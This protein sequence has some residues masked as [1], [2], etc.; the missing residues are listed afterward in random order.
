MYG[1]SVPDPMIEISPP[2]SGVLA[3]LAGF[4]DPTTRVQSASDLARALGA[5]ELLLFTTDPETATILPAPGFPQIPR[6]AKPWRQLLDDCAR[7]GPGT[8]T[9][10]NADGELRAASALAGPEGTIAL[11]LGGEP[12]E[13]TLALL[14]PALA[15]LGAL[16]RSERREIAAEARARNARTDAEAANRVKSDFLAN[17][18]HELRTPINAVL[19]YTELLNM[20]V[21]GP[22]TGDQR[23]QLERIRV[24][25]A[26]LLTLVNDVLD[27]AKVEAGQMD[28][29]VRMEPAR[30]V[31]AE[32]VEL[33]EDSARK[34]G[35][36]LDNQGA[37]SPVR[38]VGDHDRV[39]QILLNLLSNAVKFTAE[40][41]LV[42]VRCGSSP[43]AAEPARV[44]G[45]GP[46][47]YVEVED[48]GIGLSETDLARV[49]H[50][51]VQAEMGRTRSHGGTGL[52]L[53]IS[54]QLARLMGG[55]LVARSELGTG[56]CFT[57]WLPT[58]SA[59]HGPLDPSIRVG[60]S[61][62]T[63]M[64]D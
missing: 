64:E 50:P 57:V 30:E 35:V 62:R 40:G 20:G 37:A 26:H 19:G 33:V 13:R 1:G 28:F 34:R 41:G 4:A 32:A 31:I 60:A 21:T 46:W 14:T 38:Y 59:A 2:E 36:A 8:A 63:S 9:F 17:M 6:T 56:S 10:R 7:G 15:L 49:F 43:R 39:L 45:Q 52:G 51:F 18:S 24:S 11:L 27:L 12:A 48:T 3:L 29:E 54:R 22:V 58:R 47:T 16:F 42:A 23:H 25:S 53:T 5:E 61:P 55:D 44:S